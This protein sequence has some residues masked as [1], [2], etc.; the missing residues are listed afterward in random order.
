[1]LGPLRP[2]D[3]NMRRI[4]AAYAAGF[5]DEVP[6]LMMSLTLT[7]PWPLCVVFIVM[8]LQEFEKF[9]KPV[10]RRKVNVAGSQG[11]S[12]HGSGTGS[13]SGAAGADEGDDTPA[14]GEVLPPS[15]PG[16]GPATARNFPKG[17]LNPLPLP[18]RMV[19][20]H[21][22]PIL[23]VSRCLIRPTP[24]A[25]QMSTRERIQTA[26][27]GDHL[28]L[29][30]SLRAPLADLWFCVVCQIRS[31]RSSRSSSGPASSCW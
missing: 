8:V 28:L 16:F 15:S 24:C 11:P 2:A 9:N 14:V 23:A 1:M 30:V 5:T 21:C 10:R 13:G 18:K 31:T 3:K 17:M 22:D 26:V 20:S 27:Q 25:T 29:V 19:R 7:C 4:S 12:A 6:A